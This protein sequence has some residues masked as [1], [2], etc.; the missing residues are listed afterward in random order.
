ME[1]LNVSIT[2]TATVSDEGTTVSKYD[3]LLRVE[4]GASRISYTEEDE[5]GARTSTLLTIGGG[6]VSL[7]RRGAVSF[8]TV[9]REGYTH[10]SLY[11]LAGL[12]FDAEVATERLTVL[13]SALPAFDCLYTLTLG[14]EARRFALSLRLA[15]KEGAQ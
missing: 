9:Y 12:S 10:K 4:G 5:G 3:G 6:E 7:V 14:G 2:I 15:R 8:S 1:S 13:P 11:S